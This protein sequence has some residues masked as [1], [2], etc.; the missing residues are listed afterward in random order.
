MA[1]DGILLESG[2]NEVELLEFLLDG[3]SLGV[4]VLKIQ[5][6]EQYDPERIT[7]IQLA[8]PCVV[9][10]LLFRDQCI[11]MVDLT[12]HL[13][14]PVLPS[15][16]ELA[17]AIIDEVANAVQGAQQTPDSTE[18]GGESAENRLVLIMEF[19]DR[20]TAFLVDGVTRIHRV[21]W[22]DI[23]PLSPYLD[24]AG[25]K[26]TG[27]VQ[28]DGREVLIVDME[29][30][31][32]EI[33]P[34]EQ[35]SLS[36]YAD[37]SHPNFHLREELT[38]FLAEDSSVIRTRVEQELA[39]ANYTR[40]ISFPNGQECFDR[41]VEMQEA[42]ISENQP[43]G[44]SLSAIITDI[45]MPAMDGL[46]LCRNVKELLTITDVPVIMFSSLINEQIAQKCND[47]GAEAYLSKP[48]FARLV[49]LLDR[50]CIENRL[51][52]A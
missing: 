28:I 1:K 39:S 23:S 50:Y 27:S 6:I 16:D 43:L 42:A 19:N 46:T 35:A 36:A 52:R 2:T 38:V 9:G 45:E 20:K 21:S 10:T 17:P 7:H 47:V 18:P 48:Q 24:R 44:E 49:E 31:L 34:T 32:S 33:L 3:Q 30:I 41:V 22:E 25:S 40:V 29:R 11:T 14:T 13:H 51:P 5:A 15:A 12:Q 4:N 8:D 26:F 37:P